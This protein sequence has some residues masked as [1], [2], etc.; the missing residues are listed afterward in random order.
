MRELIKIN[1][2]VSSTCCLPGTEAGVGDKITKILFCSLTSNRLEMT[3]KLIDH[4]NILGSQS[5]TRG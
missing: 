2:S 1:N 3:V 5:T 4:I